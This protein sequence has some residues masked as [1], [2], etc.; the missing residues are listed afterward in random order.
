MV[1]NEMIKFPEITFYGAVSLLPQTLLWFENKAIF[2]LALAIH[3]SASV[4][5]KKN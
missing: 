4:D 2:A 5:G 3:I 1:P